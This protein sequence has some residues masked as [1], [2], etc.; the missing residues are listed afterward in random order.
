MDPIE[1]LT[2]L[3]NLTGTLAFFTIIVK[4]FINNIQDYRKT[5]HWNW[6]RTLIILIFSMNFL[7]KIFRLLYFSFGLPH[8]EWI[9][10]QEITEMSV[11]STFSGFMV[12]F[13]LTFVFYLN[14]L[15]YLLYGPLAFY[16]MTVN[17]YVT[18]GV[19]AFHIYFMY[20]GGA[21]TIITIYQA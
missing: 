4:S 12:A 2:L 19:E 14:N 20:I 21:I 1:T 9:I 18:T 8:E 16:G 5:N 6:T 7:K 10:T 13:G 11:A 17:Y 3:D 15:D